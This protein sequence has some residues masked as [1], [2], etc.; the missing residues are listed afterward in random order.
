MEAR[1]NPSMHTRVDTLRKKLVEKSLDACMVLIE[2]NRRYLSG[3]SGEDGQ[4]DE[5]A[6]ALFITH[7]HLLL[8]TDSRYEL[9]AGM[10][11]EGWDVFCYKNGAIKAFPKITGMLKIQRMGFE[12][13]RVSFKQYME[14]KKELEKSPPGVELV[15]T[16]NMVEDLRVVKQE[17]EIDATR[18]ALAIAESAFV[19]TVGSIRPGMS[20]KEVAWILERNMREAGAEGLSFPTIVASGPNSA[21]PHA[22]PTNREINEG[23]PLLFDWGARLDGYCSDTSRTLVLGAPRDPFQHVFKTV[24]KAQQMA[25]AGIQAGASTKHV[26]GLARKHI[27]DQGFKG[28]FGHALG[29]GTGLAVH[30][31]P[32][33]SPLNDTCLAEGMLVTVEPGIY[34]PDWGGVRIEN[35][36]VVRKEGAE[37]LNKLDVEISD[38]AF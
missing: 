37:V 19:E 18:Q 17:S 25:I 36:V 2:E 34:L 3:F 8:A 28:R 10:E 16:E 32:R 11:A 24:V 20:E 5:S 30:E 38:M 14:M 13:K 31:P 22:V 6:G 27:E 9:Q 35:Q 21:L 12:S 15:P 29:H 33:L 7:E 23:E 4:F 1:V 26:D